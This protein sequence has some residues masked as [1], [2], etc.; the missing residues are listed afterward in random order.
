MS[1][2]RLAS[3]P[4]AALILCGPGL[5]GGDWPGWRGPNGDGTV[6]RGRIDCHEG[7]RLVLDW[8]RT[9]G[10]GYSAISVSRGRAMQTTPVD[11]R[12]RRVSPAAYGCRDARRYARR[13]PLQTL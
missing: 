4:F 9:L 12:L 10:P 6:R 8:N 1:S 2:S 13:S 11:A 7:C 3:L 5:A